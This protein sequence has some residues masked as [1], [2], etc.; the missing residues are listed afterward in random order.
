MP[1]DEMRRR[2]QAIVAR[3]RKKKKKKFSLLLSQ[4]T[5]PSPHYEN[6]S[7]GYNGSGW[8]SKLRYLVLSVG[9]FVSLYFNCS[10]LLFSYTIA[11][12]PCNLIAKQHR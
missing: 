7:R 9:K 10:P 5:V 6:D 4:I 3:R 12:Q 8:G 11:I 1:F 2:Q